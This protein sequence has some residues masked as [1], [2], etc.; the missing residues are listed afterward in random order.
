MNHSDAV[1]EMAVE[2]YLLGELS[3]ATLDRFEE[4]LF[5]CQECTGELKAG[6]A[7]IEATRVELSNP[8]GIPS[9]KADP[10]ASWFNKLL[11]PWVLGPA[12]AACLLVIATQTLVL[13]P[14]MR[15]ELA[16]AQTPAVL[17]NLV[18]ASAGARGDGVPEI[19]APQ[20]GSFLLSV[21]FP[22]RTGFTSY[23]C[24]LYSPSGRLVWQTAITPQQAADAVLIRVPADITTDGL[25]TLLIQGSTSNASSNAKLVDLTR[26][27]FQVKIQ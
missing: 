17:N 25:N 2:R 12:L 15:Q 8:L 6:V 7:F 19:T 22:G 24:S 4:H 23:E 27:A 3:G 20:H 10:V 11:A 16:Q 26:Y 21:D 18:L 5:E 13:M 9:S 1:R 14:R